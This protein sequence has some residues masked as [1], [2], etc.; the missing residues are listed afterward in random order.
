MEIGHLLTFY[1]SIACFKMDDQENPEETNA[2]RK[3]LE[4][5]R[6]MS[7]E[8][9]R[10]PINATSNL[11]VTTDIRPVKAAETPRNQITSNGCREKK[12]VN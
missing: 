2:G 11:E 12:G 3:V 10:R 8:G 5:E 7:L 9:R 1:L 4:M 6:D